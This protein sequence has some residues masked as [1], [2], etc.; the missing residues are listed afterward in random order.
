VFEY[1]DL[2]ILLNLPEAMVLSCLGQF[3]STRPSEKLVAFG[4]VKFN[5]MR[6]ESEPD[7]TFGPPFSKR[8]VCGHYE[9]TEP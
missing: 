6:L 5:Q 9:I 8:V 2:R 3:P 4:T 1:V 7:N